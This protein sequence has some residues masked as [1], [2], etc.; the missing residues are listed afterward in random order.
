MA[1]A[2]SEVAQHANL[3]GSTGRTR[4]AAGDAWEE[5]GLVFSSAVGK[6]LDSTNVR[7]AFRQAINKAE[8]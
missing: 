6:E 3:A 4:L 7:R 5:N 1:C 8:G 2:E